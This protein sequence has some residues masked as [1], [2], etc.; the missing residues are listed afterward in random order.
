MVKQWHRMDPNGR[1]GL[2]NRN[3]VR[4]PKGNEVRKQSEGPRY[5]C[6]ELSEERKTCVH[7]RTLIHPDN[8]ERAPFRLLSRVRHL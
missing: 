5:P 8:D 1:N 7:V 2:K 4:S 6:W 3:E